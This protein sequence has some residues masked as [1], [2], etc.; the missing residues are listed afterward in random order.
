MAGI[1]VCATLGGNTG[2]PDCDVRM[3]R[4]KFTGLSTAREFTAAELATSEAF[5][6]ALQAAMLLANADANK[7]FMFP[8]MREAT[9]NSGDPATGALADGYEEVLNEA[10]PKYLLRSTPGVC[11]QQAMASF[12]GY[13]GRQFIIDENNILWYKVTSTGGGKGFSTGYLYTNPPKFKGSGDVQTANTRLTFGSIDE[14]KSGVGALKLDFAISDLDN[15]QDVVLDDRET[16]NASGALN[17]VFIIGGKIKCEGT[18]I[19]AAYSTALANV[20]RWRA[21]TADGTPIVITSV[22]V[23][24]TLLGWNITLT[25]ATFTSMPVGTVF[26]IDLATPD[27]LKAAGVT[28]IEGNKIRFVKF[29]A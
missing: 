24:P 15:I 8:E 11:V 3:G 2:K 13:P 16:E 7:V 19:Y 6:E 25:G 10:L 23:N 26:Y 28:G 20:A 1:N 27:V 17:N 22:T 29:A 5:Q 12:N 21:Y 9:D 14:F 4:I 18:D